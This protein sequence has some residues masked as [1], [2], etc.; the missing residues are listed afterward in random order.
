MYETVGAF[1][2]V[3]CSIVLLIIWCLNQKWRSLHNFISLH[4][5]VFGTCHL[6]S[7]AVN[8]FLLQ[9]LNCEKFCSLITGY[10]FL[11][12]SCW[13]ICA[14]L[15]AYLRLV[16]LVPGKI[17]YEKRKAA[18]FSYGLL[19]T[20]KVICDGIVP[21]IFN[22]T[23]ESDFFITAFSVYII[24]SANLF[25]FLS[26]IRSVFG[27]DK[28]IVRK[29]GARVIPIIGVAVLCDIITSLVL[30]DPVIVIIDLDYFTDVLFSYRLVIHTFIVLFNRT[31]REYW[32]KR[33]DLMKLRKFHA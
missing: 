19:L 3:I 7:V 32:K 23:S 8:D 16:L 27:G 2:S 28:T 24:M 31:S 9:D 15:V 4:Q 12:S 1:L 25:I 14:S 17:M 22:L 26:V 29:N 20:V 10:L 11:V 18:L 5:I 6:C 30:L 21:M 13:T 33:I